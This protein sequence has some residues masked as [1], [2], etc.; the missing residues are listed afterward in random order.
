MAAKGDG[1]SVRRLGEGDIGAYRA[2]IE[3]YRIAFEDDGNYPP[4]G[5]SEAWIA[6]RLRDPG[7]IMM[8]A[9]KDGAII[10][11]LSA[12]IL[13]KFE[14]ERSEVYIYDLA[15]LDAFRRQGAATALIEGLKPVARAAGAWVIYVQ[16]D[17]EDPPAIALYTR[18]GVREDV[19]HFDIAPD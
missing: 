18:L 1:L 19:L 17:Y 15:V 5:V 8:V 7:L 3:V 16:A 9:E 11:G 10:G 4:G 2:L 6:E 14:L 12:Y 13:Q